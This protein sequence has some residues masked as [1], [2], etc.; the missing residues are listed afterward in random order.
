M[1]EWTF[2]HCSNCYFLN[3]RWKCWRT[4]GHCEGITQQIYRYINGTHSICIVFRLLHHIPAKNSH[5]IPSWKEGVIKNPLNIAVSAKPM[6]RY[7]RYIESKQFPKFRHNIF[8]KPIEVVEGFKNSKPFDEFPK[9]VLQSIPTSCLPLCG[10]I[11][12]FSQLNNRL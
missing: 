7:V 12:W 6:N 2:V 4:L 8:G 10:F 9:C 5:R 1:Q 11:A 3:K